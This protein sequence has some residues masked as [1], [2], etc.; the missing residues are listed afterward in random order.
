MEKCQL[1]GAPGATPISSALHRHFL[2]PVVCRVFCSLG[3]LLLTKK[4]NHD[5]KVESYFIW[6][7]CL[8]HRARDSI[9]V[10]LRKLFQGGRRRSQ[11]IYKLATKGVD[12]LNIKDQIDIKLRNLALYIWEDAS[13][14]THRIHSFHV[15]LRCLGP[16]LFLCSPCFLHFPN[17]SAITVGVAASARLDCSLGSLINIWRPEITDACDISC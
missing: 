17:S 12:S 10:A 11:A 7:E 13:L 6:W 8:G 14:S 1:C 15:H 2:S 5:L 3:G 4:Y 9:S 16:I